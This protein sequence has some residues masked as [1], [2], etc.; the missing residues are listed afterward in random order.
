M[1]AI[2]NEQQWQSVWLCSCLY[3]LSAS[4]CYSCLC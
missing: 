2:D 1:A 4:T 3:A